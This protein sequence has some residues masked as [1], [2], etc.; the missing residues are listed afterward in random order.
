MLFG[1][2]VLSRSDRQMALNDIFYYVPLIFRTDLTIQL[3]IIFTVSNVKRFEWLKCSTIWLVNQTYVTTT[4]LFYFQH[5]HILQ[6]HVY[7]LTV[8]NINLDL[9]SEVEF[10]S[11]VQIGESISKSEIQNQIVP[12][13]YCRF[14]AQYIKIIKLQS[15]SSL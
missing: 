6:T 14:R 5:P 15:N 7:T 4:T 3:Y 12:L 1:G 13:Y 9:D 2:S 11:E 8:W 10:E